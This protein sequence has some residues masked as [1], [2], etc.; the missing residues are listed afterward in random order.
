MTEPQAL[1]TGE[2]GDTPLGGLLFSVHQK[3]LS[4]SIVLAETPERLHCVSFRNGYPCKVRPADS[5]EMTGE[6]LVELGAIEALQLKQ[7]LEH[8]SASGVL[9]GVAALQLGYAQPQDVTAALTLQV[10]RRV[11]SLFSVATGTYGFYAEDFLASF[12][13]NDSPQV[14]PLTA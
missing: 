7:V 11:A 3:Q 6:L 5:E 2:M 8:A 4:G 1:A 10:T 13:G 14:D 9:T 12:G